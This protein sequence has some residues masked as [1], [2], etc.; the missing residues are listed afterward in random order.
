MLKVIYRKENHT[1]FLD[2]LIINEKPNLHYSTN[3]GIR[4]EQI[5]CYLSDSLPAKLGVFFR[6]V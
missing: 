6:M 1:D 4:G 3:S 2:F 5:P